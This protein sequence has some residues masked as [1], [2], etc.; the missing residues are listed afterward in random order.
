MRQFMGVR[1]EEALDART[2]E[3]V[4]LAASAVAGCGP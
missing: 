3:L 1:F 2:K 4:M